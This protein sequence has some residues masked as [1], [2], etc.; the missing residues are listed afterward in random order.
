MQVTWGLENHV[1]MFK[2]HPKT[3]GQLSKDFMLMSGL[4]FSFHSVWSFPA[5]IRS[6]RELWL[7]IHNS[8]FPFVMGPLSDQPALSRSRSRSS[9]P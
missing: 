6:T 2:P 3:N 9:S 8:L 1:K 7:L 5:L 4:R